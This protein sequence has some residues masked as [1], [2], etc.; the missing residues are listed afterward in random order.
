MKNNKSLFPKS[1]EI[2][3]FFLKALNNLLKNEIKSVEAYD[4]FIQICE[5][6]EKLSRCYLFNIVNMT[7]FCFAFEEM[8]K[9][10]QKQNSYKKQIDLYYVIIKMFFY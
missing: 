2:I 10:F 3:S 5:I 9:Y 7:R 4:T 1:S 6:L 8:F